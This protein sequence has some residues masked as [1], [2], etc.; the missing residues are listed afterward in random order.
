M[1]DARA[2]RAWK[3]VFL[4]C[5][6]AGFLGAHRF[7]VGRKGSAFAQLATFG[8]CGIWSAYDLY[9]LWI[10]RFEDGDGRALGRG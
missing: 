5:L 1:S 8:G 6:L 10:H 7:Y 9:C 2:P 4:L 3:S